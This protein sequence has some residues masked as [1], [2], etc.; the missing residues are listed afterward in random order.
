MVCS[1]F[2]FRGVDMNSQISAERPICYDV[3]LDKYLFREIIDECLRGHQ[4]VLSGAAGVGN[5]RVA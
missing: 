4:K 3:S 2:I 5:R 1:K